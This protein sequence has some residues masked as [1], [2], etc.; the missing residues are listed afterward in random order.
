MNM[1]YGLREQYAN[2]RV[3]QNVGLWLADDI[4]AVDINHLIGL[5]SDTQYTAQFQAAEADQ[6]LVARP[7]FE[8]LQDNF[9][10]QLINH[11]D[12]DM[13]Y[14]TANEFVQKV[15]AMHLE[16]N[17]SFPQDTE[18]EWVE[19]DN[20][21][22]SADLEADPVQYGML[23]NNQILYAHDG[24]HLYMASEFDLTDGQYTADQWVTNK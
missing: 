13:A 23:I 6:L 16:T 9:D 18:I 7:V 20:I 14:E 10:N 17:T 19:A 15:L 24:S 1:A 8:I 3:Y 5:D 21:Q 2:A 11:N 22:L 4:I 12:F